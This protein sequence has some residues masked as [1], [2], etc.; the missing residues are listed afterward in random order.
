L[1]LLCGIP[2]ES[3]VETVARALDAI[4]ADYLVLNQRRVAT[5]SIELDGVGATGVLRYDGRAVD[6]ETVGGVL[7][8]MMD[9]AR[10]PE[11]A[12][13]PADSPRL[14]RAR[15]LHDL[16]A[17]WAEV[18][19]GPI[20]NR[21]SAM[22]SNFSKPYQQQLIVAAGFATPA[23]LVTND[24]DAVCAFAAEHGRVIFKSISS[25]RSIVKELTDAEMERLE[26]IRWCPVQFQQRI[27]GDDM[28]V[29]TVGERV[30]ATRMR[31]A[32]TDYRYASRQVG[33]GA[34]FEP[35][36]LDDEVAERCVALGRSLGLEVAGIDF[37]APPD[38]PLV[39]LEV[40]PSPVFSYYE[41]NTG[42][43]IAAA[44]AELL[45][46]PALVGR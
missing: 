40:N 43:P 34:E 44:V 2:S 37:K 6:L 36:E 42:Q 4:G 21:Y 46:S 9:D 14:A 45:A 12:G 11:L 33:R 29:H 17:R 8:R 7:L 25:E 26:A 23:T 15:M 16:I 31:T 28:R 1:I 19:P 27:E 13:E 10:L 39:C 24:P 18:A 3:G 20:V 41:A 35:A 38:G 30:F 5:T 22:G 32:A